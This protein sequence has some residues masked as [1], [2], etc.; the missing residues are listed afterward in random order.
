MKR[1]LRLTTFASGCFSFVLVM[2]G[3]MAWAAPQNQPNTPP[4]TLAEY[5]ALTSGS[6][7]KDA[8]AKIKLLDDFVAQYPNS[9]LLPFVYTEYYQTFFRLQNYPQAVV[10][11]DRLLA[12][13]DKVVPE[14]SAYESS[15]AAAGAIV[16]VRLS[17]LA[18]R[19]EAY[20]VDCD[21]S[22]FQ[23]PEAST[24]AK[25]LATQGLELL[26]QSPKPSILLDADYSMMK[27]NWGSLFESAQRIAEARLK[28]DA[29]VCAP[30]PPPPPKPPAPNARFNRIIQ[31]LL[32]E[33]RQSPVQ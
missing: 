8:N 6:A 7:Q 22:V 16:L 26:S 11:V 27:V 19:A 5:N 17:A 18:T 30:P 24:K 4:Y 29:V 12:L 14:N 2:A 33:Q 10:F 28:G 20:A 21:D 31:D 9:A 1:A 32:N 3:S 15:E 23:T 25:D 13:G